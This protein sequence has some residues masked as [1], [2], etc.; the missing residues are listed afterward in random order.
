MIQ[1]H[2]NTAL[3]DSRN[4]SSLLQH[5]KMGRAIQPPLLH[6]LPALTPI[7]TPT[8]LPAADVIAVKRTAA[9]KATEAPNE[10]ERARERKRE[11]GETEIG[12][13]PRGITIPMTPNLPTMKFIP[14]LHSVK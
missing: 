9:E 14:K 6:P 2:T 7:L 8:T 3:I 10:K 13:N 1:I 4:S 11:N 5:P 12:E